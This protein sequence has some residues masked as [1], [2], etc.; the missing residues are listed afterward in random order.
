[1][2]PLYKRQGTTAP[3]WTSFDETRLKKDAVRRKLWY[4]YLLDEGF[5]CLAVAHNYN[6]DH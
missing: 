4:Q 1:M 6:V 2:G 5:L 3:P